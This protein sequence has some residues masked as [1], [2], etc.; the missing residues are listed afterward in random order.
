MQ[1]CMSNWL[2]SYFVLLLLWCQGIFIFMCV[3]TFEFGSLGE[4]QVINLVAAWWNPCS[5]ETCSTSHLQNR[6]VFVFLAWQ[7]T[8]LAY[9]PI[10]FQKK[11]PILPMKCFKRKTHLLGKPRWSS[12]LALPLLRGET[13]RA[14]LKVTRSGEIHAASMPCG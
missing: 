6:M 3:Q 5:H 1:R 9:C 11:T 13:L 4:K 14:E 10:M 12:P 7:N 8:T 2:S